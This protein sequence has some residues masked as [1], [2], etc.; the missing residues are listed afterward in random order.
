MLRQ[1]QKARSKSKQKKS[2]ALIYVLFGSNE[3]DNKTS[4]YEGE[5]PSEVDSN[6][7]KVKKKLTS[8]RCTKPDEADIKRVVKYTHEKLDPRH[9][10]DHTFDN[11][12]FHML[13]AEELELASQPNITNEERDTRIAIAKTLCYH[14]SYVEETI[15]REG[16]DQMLKKIERGIQNWDPVLGEHLHE[17]LDYKAN[18]MMRER[19][20]QEKVTPFTKVEHRK[21]SK[22]QHE[23]NTEKQEK[24]SEVKDRIIYCSD[25]NNGSCSFADHHDGKFAG[26]KCVKFHICRKCYSQGHEIRSYKDGSDECP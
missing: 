20:Q 16:Y 12:P 6:H 25:W 3:S 11:L 22:P 9:S 15:L 19:F 7:D 26:R 10:N 13:I 14:R 2:K 1:L 4:E 8:G 5:A 24:S 21:G 18:V 23:R 17:F